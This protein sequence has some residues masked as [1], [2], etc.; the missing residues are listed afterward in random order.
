KE[1]N[2]KSLEFQVKLGKFDISGISSS[3]ARLTSDLNKLSNIEFDGLNKLETN[4]KNIN[5]LMDK[6]NKISN[7]NTNVDIESNVGNS[8]KRL[9]G[10]Q[11]ESLRYINELN[12]MS[13]E[14]DNMLSQYNKN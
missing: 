4:L 8:V 7:T 14:M 6:Q 13:K 1:Y 10:D 9:V 3:I 5:K 2:D 12:Q 11:K